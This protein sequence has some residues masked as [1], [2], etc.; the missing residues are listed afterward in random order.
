MIEKGNINLF[1]NPIK[2]EMRELISHI[3][4]TTYIDKLTPVEIDGRFIVLETPNESFAKYITSTLAA[5]MREAIKKADV[6]LVDFRLKIANTENYVLNTPEERY[7]ESLTKINPTY[8]F[9]SFVETPN[10]KF[11]YDIVQRIAAAPDGKYS[12][13]F[14]FGDTSVGKTHLM[15]AIA[16]QII[17]EKSKH[18]V[19][20]A[21]CERFVNEI[22]DTI[23]TAKGHGA[24]KH[25]NILRQHYRNVD[26][27]IIDD[28]QYLA[29]KKAVQ[30][31]LLYIFNELVNRGK[32]III[33]SDKSPNDLPAF[34]EKLRSRFLNGL[35]FEL[36][37]PDLESR[38][39]I[40]KS[41]MYEMHCVVPNDVLA[42]LAQD[43][44]DDIRK[45][46]GSFKKFVAVARSCEEPISVSFVKESL[47]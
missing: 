40:L 42:F 31:E 32:Q 4:Y 24:R 16:N 36:L 28:I 20:F 7:K 11:L 27:L 10:N 44:S 47:K 5:K 13:L 30:E 37:P 38:I 45:M 22:I 8:T 19:T 35:V 39:T 26:V 18:K 9:D 21:T 43:K 41:K 6:G 2:K 29:N 34:D 17:A 14:I 12:P 33:S 25:G 3:N 15:H 1:Y 46:L 23:F